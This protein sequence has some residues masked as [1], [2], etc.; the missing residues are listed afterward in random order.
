MSGERLLDE[1][2]NT[3][4]TKRKNPG[5]GPNSRKRKGKAMAVEE[6]EF[7]SG[8][9][10]DSEIDG[11]PVYAESGDSSSSDNDHDHDGDVNPDQRDLQAMKSTGVEMQHARRTTRRLKNVNALVYN[12]QT[13]KK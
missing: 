11:S 6:D 13:K 10:T 5:D 12:N 9:D 8:D 4:A 7:A 2:I 3:W 1:P